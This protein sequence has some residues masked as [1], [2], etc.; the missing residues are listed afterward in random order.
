V[1]R[2]AAATHVSV[3]LRWIMDRLHLT[4]TDDGRGVSGRTR[5]GEDAEL[6]AGVGIRSI[7]ARVRQLDGD[8][9]IRSG[10]LGTSIHAAIPVK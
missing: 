6:R 1:H 7:R 4:I 10:P 5:Q 9:K 8:I 2:H 3:D